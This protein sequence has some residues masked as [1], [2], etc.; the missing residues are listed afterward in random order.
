MSESGVAMFQQ[1][2]AFWLTKPRKRIPWVLCK[3]DDDV[4][5]RGPRLPTC[6]NSILS[7]ICYPREVPTSKSVSW[8]DLVD[9]VSFRRTLVDTL[10]WLNPAMEW[11]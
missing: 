11:K 4:W 7:T 2:R 9:R 1:A 8:Y 6:Y 10:Y 5:E 3:S